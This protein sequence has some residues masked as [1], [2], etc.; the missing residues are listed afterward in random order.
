MQDTSVTTSLKSFY[1]EALR[2]NKTWRLHSYKR[3]L[4]HEVRA[5]QDI[6]LAQRGMITK[7]SC[8]VG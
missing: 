7:A 3:E 2:R 1:A 8:Y 5:C 4:V 6:Y